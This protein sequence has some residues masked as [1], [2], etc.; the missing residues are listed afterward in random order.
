MTTTWNNC[1]QP[2]VRFFGLT[3]VVVV[4]SFL[5]RFRA[6]GLGVLRVGERLKRGNILVQGSQVLLNHIGQFG[7]LDWAVVEER[8]PFRH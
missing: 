2:P 3:Y 4:L 8:F 5:I 6:V 7:D 1:Q